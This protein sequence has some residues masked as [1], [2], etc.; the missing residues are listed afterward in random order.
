MEIPIYKRTSN[1]P[2]DMW[3][4]SYVAAICAHKCICSQIRFPV[5]YADL[6]THLEKNRKEM[7]KRDGTIGRNARER[8]EES[9]FSTD[10]KIGS[11]SDINQKHTV[12]SEIDFVTA[13]EI[14]DGA[15]KHVYDY[16]IARAHVREESTWKSLEV[17]EYS[18]KSKFLSYTGKVV[19]TM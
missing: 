3:V 1:I 4:S 7:F 6:C 19:L 12:H 13:S 16:V 14:I 5:A 8:K 9:L 11:R 17:Y 15:N 2:W 18:A 10:S